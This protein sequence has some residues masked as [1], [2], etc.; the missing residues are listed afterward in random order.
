MKLQGRI[1]GWFVVTALVVLLAVFVTPLKTHAAAPSKAEITAAKA[2]FK[3]ADKKKWN[4]FRKHRNQV[5]HTD[6]RKIL[7]WIDLKSEGNSHTFDEITAFIADNPDWPGQ[8]TLQRRAEETMPPGL[9]DERVAAW[10]SEREPVSVDGRIR[11]GAALLNSGKR[12]EARVFLKDTWINGDFGP[13]QERQY[14]KLYAKHLDR[15]DHKARLD[16]LLWDD[17]HV[18]AKRMLNKVD[19]NH[20]LLAI[21]RSRLALRKGGVDRAIA[22]VPK[23]L[24]NDP[25]LIY[26]RIR[27]RRRKG[28]EGQALEL[29]L[30]MKPTDQAPEQWWEERSILTRIA[31]KKGQVT[32]AYRIAKNHGLESGSQFAAAEW[33][34]GWIA[35]RYLGDA[36][37]AL[38]HFSNLYGK[39]NFPISRARAAYWAGR[40][41][42]ALNQKK[43]AALWY[44]IGSRFPTTF[45]GQ[46][47]GA[48][49]GKSALHIPPDARPDAQET[50]I[51]EKN[52]L[53]RMA[54]LLDRIGEVKRVNPFLLR[55][56]D[57][58]Q[59]AGWRALTADLA[60]ELERPDLAV[61]IAKKS[62]LAG[63]PL[64]APG[65]PKI[66][67]PD[68][69]ISKKLPTPEKPLVL[70]VIRQESGFNPRAISRAGARGMMQLMPTT[71]KRLARKSKV[72]Y[73]KTRLTSDP[74]YNMTIG[75]TYLATLLDRYEGSYILS[76]AAYNA[77]P[78]RV[79]AWI[80]AFGDPREGI[81]DP[82]DWIENIPF[83]ETRNY[84]QRILESLQVYRARLGNTQIALT[85]EQDLNR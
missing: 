48:K 42:E 9:S 11:Y 10:F 46:L 8:W 4:T 83:N 68:A 70:S 41:N 76:L 5:R 81:A 31:L 43:S 51:F 36:D 38:N 64:I 20:R 57:L 77:G 40:A 54:L 62:V 73:S 27:W 74:D 75:Q 7:D 58:S 50:G 85:L 69:H 1:N 66:T 25:G 17:R 67:L 65:Y 6:L 13:R 45:Y 61:R 60:L 19:K 78:S 71:A 15:A 33:L 12:D 32:D 72:R 18:A 47:A 82:V 29:M 26:E 21:A 34:A 37:V 79:K 28:R 55:L 53:V 3:A 22:Q 2:A 39:V 80:G 56:V 35:L 44:G 59:S 49:E 52:E 23:S 24:K 84:V 14:L 16:R 30:S 63:Q